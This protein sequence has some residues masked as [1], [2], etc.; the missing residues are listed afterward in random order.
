MSLQTARLADLD[1]W[2]GKVGKWG[3]LGRPMQNNMA[4]KHPAIP[5]SHNPSRLQPN[6]TR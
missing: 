1:A 2:V 4:G 3:N 5:P 6:R